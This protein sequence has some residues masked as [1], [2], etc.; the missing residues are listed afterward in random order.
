MNFFDVLVLCCVNREPRK[1]GAIDLGISLRQIYRDRRIA[2]EKFAD[3]S[4]SV[5]LTRERSRR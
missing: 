3:L 2:R 1:N 5:S 4:R